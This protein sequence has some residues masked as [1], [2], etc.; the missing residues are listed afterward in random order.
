[1][2]AIILYLLTVFVG[3][4]PVYIAHARGQ[5][6]ELATTLG[7]A[8]ERAGKSYGLPPRLI[9]ALAYSETGLNGKMVG[10]VGE[11][12]VMQV[13]PR[14]AAGAVYAR[15]CSSHTLECDAWNVHLGAQM[16]SECFARCGTLGMAVGCYKSGRCVQGPAAGRVLSMWRWSEG[17]L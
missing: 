9:L 16:L 13:H 6:D 10:K 2:K 7:D 5:A 17:W 8:F 12:G 3:A 14:S 4:E 11:L 1:M 15:S